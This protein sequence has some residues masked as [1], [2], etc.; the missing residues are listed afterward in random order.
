MGR[1]PSE[2]PR[3]GLGS[4]CTCEES[5]RLYERIELAKQIRYDLVELV[6]NRQHISIIDLTIPFQ[7]ATSG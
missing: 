3:L 4:Q 7:Q 2:Q 1:H 6:H 5:Q